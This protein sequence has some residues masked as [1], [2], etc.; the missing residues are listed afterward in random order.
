MTES[1][2]PNNLL[3]NTIRRFFMRHQILFKNISY[4]S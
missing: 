2:Y 3:Q 4:R 1:V